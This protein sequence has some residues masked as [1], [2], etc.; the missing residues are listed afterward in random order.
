MY[1]FNT[2]DFQT[3]TPVVWHIIKEAEVP[4]SP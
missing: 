1:G 2:G 3:L 4:A